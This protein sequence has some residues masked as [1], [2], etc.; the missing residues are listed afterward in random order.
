[1]SGLRRLARFLPPLAWMGV[2]ALLS[3]GLFGADETGALLL[4]LLGRFLPGADPGLLHAVH[5][6]LR[7]L[8]H[9]VEYGILAVLWLRSLGPD[10]RA[11]ALA[12]GLSALYAVA[13]EAHQSFVPNRTAAVLDVAIDAAGALVALAWV[14]GRGR[15]AIA[16]LRLLRWTAAVVAAGSLLAAVVD[17]SLGLTAWDLVG[18]GL[19]AAGAVW[20]LRR[21]EARWRAS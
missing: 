6:A 8:A 10:R 7:K 1:M 14:R 19:G 15:V 16:G 13:D 3:G 12:I 5:A 4:P 11:A 21:L 17:W 18:A 9:V 20:A 2:I